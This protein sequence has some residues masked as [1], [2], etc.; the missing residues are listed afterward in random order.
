MD[1]NECRINDN[2]PCNNGGYCENLDGSYR[3]ICLLGF[4]GNRC[5]S[6]DD[7]CQSNPCQKLVLIL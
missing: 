5:E 2:N 3:C 4:V 7:E 6:I 1:I